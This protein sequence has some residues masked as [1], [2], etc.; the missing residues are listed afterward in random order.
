[1]I[2]SCTPDILHKE[3]K[4]AML[5]EVKETVAFFKYSTIHLMSLMN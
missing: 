1:M 5:T 4:K 2:P 3:Y